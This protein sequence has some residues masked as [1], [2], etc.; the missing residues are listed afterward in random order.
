MS[1]PKQAPPVQRP[2]IVEPHRVVEVEEGTPQQRLG[3]RV[4][5]LHGANYNDPAPYAVPLLPRMRASAQPAAAAAP[6]V[7][8]DQPAAIAA[9][10]TAMRGWAPRA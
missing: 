10:A 8:R 4:L 2:E 1:L 3:T 7:C 5:L 9:G 6:A